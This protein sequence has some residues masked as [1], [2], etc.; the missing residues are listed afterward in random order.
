MLAF[1]EDGSGYSLLSTRAAYADADALFAALLA[2]ARGE[3]ETALRPPGV[4]VRSRR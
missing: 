2:A 3:R 1:A 4:P